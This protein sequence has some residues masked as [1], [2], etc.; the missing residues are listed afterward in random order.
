MSALLDLQRRFRAALLGE[1]EQC[2]ADLIRDDVPG[3]I[4][5]LQ[6][7]RNNTLLLLTEALRSNF[8][9]T[10]RIVDERFFAYAAAS[11]IPAHPPRQPRLAEYGAEFPQFLADFEPAATLP[12]LADLARLEWSM[13]ECQESADEPSLGPADLEGLR[14]DALPGMRLARHPAC[15]LMASAWPVDAIRA[16]ALAGGKEQPPVIEGNPVWLI[17]R[18]VGEEVALRRCPEGDFAL[19]D[20]LFS[21]LSLGEALETSIVSPAPVLAA[22]LRDGLIGML[23]KT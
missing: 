8:S 20:S 21:G 2:L 5:R 6:I 9:A 3:P 11:F 14:L 17:I 13:L 19:L 23:S 7:Y 18:R 16:F 10:S 12:W 15:R 1:E 4:E 22:A